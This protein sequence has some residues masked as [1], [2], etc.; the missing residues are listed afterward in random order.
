[1]VSRPVAL[2][3]LALLLSSCGQAARGAAL[4]HGEVFAG[5]TPWQTSCEFTGEAVVHGALPFRIEVARR[6]VQDPRTGRR[7]LPSG[8]TV[9]IRN[10]LLP[11][12]GIPLPVGEL[13]GP[14]AVLRSVVPGEADPASV[15]DGN[16][17]RFS[18]GGFELHATA[19]YVLVDYA[20]KAPGDGVHGE[21]ELSFQTGETV[22]GTFASTFAD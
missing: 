20:G 5:R 10:N 3:L 13:E 12:S 7:G 1:M 14:Q 9:E 17:V 18:D 8:L 2:F 11:G 21:F 15:N 19:G 6:P 16:D 4:V 22:R